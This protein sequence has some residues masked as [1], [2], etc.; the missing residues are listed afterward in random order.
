[1]CGGK[2]R[3]KPNG[4]FMRGNLKSDGHKL[5]Q[6]EGKTGQRGRNWGK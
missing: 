2:G 6:E 4:R 5:M 3:K 1:M